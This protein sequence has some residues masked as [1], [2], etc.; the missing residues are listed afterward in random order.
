MHAS[1]EHK[2]KR[3]VGWI[4]EK[5][6]ENKVLTEGTH[7]EIVSAVLLA[8]PVPHLVLLLHAVSSIFLYFSCSGQIV[9]RLRVTR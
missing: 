3:R 2:H 5:K 1:I 7:A 4:V 9:F 6:R 8:L